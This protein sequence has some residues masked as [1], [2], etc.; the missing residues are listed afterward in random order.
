M[1]SANGTGGNVCKKQSV[2]VMELLNQLTKSEQ[3]NCKIFFA[4]D[5]KV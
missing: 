2:Q 4:I 1:D 3:L 5:C